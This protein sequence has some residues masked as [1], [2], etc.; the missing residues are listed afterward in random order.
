M[1]LRPV[2]ED[3]ERAPVAARREATEEAGAAA[4]ERE[5]SVEEMSHTVARQGTDTIA[6]RTCG[7]LISSKMLGGASQ[8][9]SKIRVKCNGK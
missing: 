1:D 9:V 5:R 4:I 2:F 7:S 3:L 8:T 6:A